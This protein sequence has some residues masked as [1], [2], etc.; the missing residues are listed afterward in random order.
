MKHWSNCPKRLLNLR[1]WTYLEIDSRRTQANTWKFK[2]NTA[3][4]QGMKLD[5]FQSFPAT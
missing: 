5:E 3:F 1:S 4:G 2:G